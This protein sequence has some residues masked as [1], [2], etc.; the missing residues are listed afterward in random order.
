M[1][2]AITNQGGFHGTSS[3]LLD[4]LTPGGDWR[5]PKGWPRDSRAVTTILHRIAPAL[6]K[7]GWSFAEDKDSHSK[8]ITWS[9]RPPA[10]A[11]MAR[12][13]YRSSPQPPAAGR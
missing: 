8:L 4:L 1:Q 13:D 7:L 2:K 6:R 12:A 3:Q 10:P 9:F 5:P 11:E